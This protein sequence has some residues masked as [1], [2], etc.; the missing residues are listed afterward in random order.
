[1]ALGSMQ[2]AKYNVFFEAE[3]IRDGL[4]GFLAF[5]KGIYLRNVLGNAAMFP[6]Q[7]I[8]QVKDEFVDE[9]AQA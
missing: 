7:S 2:L 6:A 8:Q 9:Y 1:M 3:T 4:P 5:Q